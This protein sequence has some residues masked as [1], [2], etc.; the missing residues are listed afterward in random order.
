M[1]K[2]IAILLAL[3]MVFALAGCDA[4]DYKKA[5][6]AMDSGDYAAASTAFKALG[7][8]KDSADLAKKCDYNLAKAAL[9]AKNYAD[10]VKGFEALGDYEDSADCLAQAKDALTA[11]ALVGD[12]EGDAMDLSNSILSALTTAGDGMTDA[13]SYCEFGPFEVTPSMSLREDGTCTVAID[14]DSFRSAMSGFMSAL[15]AGIKKYYVAAVEASLAQQGYTLE[16]AY[17]ELGV[18]D[19]DGLLQA[20][21]GMSFDE[22]FDS[23]GLDSLLDSVSSNL[24]VLGTYT[25]ENGTVKISSSGDVEL[26]DYDESAGTVTLTGTESGST[27]GYP[28]VYH[29]K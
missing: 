10:A 21:I 3:T 13:L 16:D 12:W 17:A 1:K 2:I 19:E 4:S 9:D 7:D 11:K 22:L 26:G 25:V 23:L 14:E 29:R 18:T 8:Y 28:Q 5:V 15:K 24:S 20:S 6:S 27:E